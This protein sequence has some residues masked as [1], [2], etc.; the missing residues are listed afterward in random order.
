[1]GT[2]GDVTEVVQGSKLLYLSGVVLWSIVTNQYRWY[3]MSGENGLQGTDDTG[4]SCGCKCL[5]FHVPREVVSYQ[6]VGLPIQL[7]QV[8]SYLLPQ[9]TWQG[10]GNHWLYVSTL[11]LA[12]L[13]Q[14]LMTCFTCCEIP[15]HQTNVDTWRRHRWNP[16]FPLWIFLSVSCCTLCGITIGW[17]QN[18]RS[19]WRESSPLM[20]Q[21]H[22]TSPVIW[23]LFGNPCLQKV[24]NWE[25]VLSCCCTILNCWRPLAL[26]GR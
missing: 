26:P 19:T 25:Q 17:P 7:K 2:A 22:K 4:W 14:L 18:S 6:E 1:M 3:S 21:Y 15:G 5:N 11:A 9:V 12:H 23:L 8:G 20:G 16:W 13:G 24:I 10:W